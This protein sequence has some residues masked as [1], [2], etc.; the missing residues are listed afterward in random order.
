MSS[1]AIASP[2]EGR[3]RAILDDLI[4]QRQRMRHAETEGGLLEANRLSIVY[5]QR[6]LSLCL[7]DEHG[8]R[9]SAA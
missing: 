3:I 1:A 7:T 9:G 8:R 5:W 6:Q 4:S 2:R